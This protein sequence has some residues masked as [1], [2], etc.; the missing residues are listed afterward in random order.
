MVLKISQNDSGKMCWQIHSQLGQINFAILTNKFRKK[1]NPNETECR[2]GASRRASD[3]WEARCLD[4]Y[5]FNSKKKFPIWTNTIHFLKREI[6]KESNETEWRGS[7]S[8][9]ASD[10]SGGGEMLMDWSPRN[11]F[12]LDSTLCFLLTNIC[13]FL[14]IFQIS[15]ILFCWQTGHQISAM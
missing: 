2:V 9:R 14:Q 3:N 10:N 11:R 13:L 8:R 5:I 15:Q 7:A 6:P 12:L 1:R 4:K